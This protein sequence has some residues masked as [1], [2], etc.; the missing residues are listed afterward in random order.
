MLG[1]LGIEHDVEIGVAEPREVGRRRAQRRDDV[2]VDAEAGEQGGDLADVVAVA[3]AERRGA[4][5]VA[6]RPRAAA[7]ALRAVR[8]APGPASARTSW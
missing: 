6:A 7:R 8:P 2:D 1:D 5:H 3:E 4:E